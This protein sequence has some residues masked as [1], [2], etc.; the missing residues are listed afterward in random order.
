[1]MIQ[2]LVH[3]DAPLLRRQR[4]KERMRVTG[5]LRFSTL[6]K[7]PNFDFELLLFA[8]KIPLIG[9]HELRVGGIAA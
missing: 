4:T 9:H 2:V 7:L 5:T 1:M 3:A 8:Q 6:V